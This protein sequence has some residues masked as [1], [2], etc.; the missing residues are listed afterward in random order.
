MKALPMKNYESD[1]KTEILLCDFF[2][3][4]F[5]L[6]TMSPGWHLTTIKTSEIVSAVLKDIPLIY[7]IENRASLFF[8]AENY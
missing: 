2:D 4:K 5:S 3:M 1:C 6:A 7:V 8:L